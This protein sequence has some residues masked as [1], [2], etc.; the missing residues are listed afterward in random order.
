MANFAS[1]RGPV[2]L[3]RIYVQTAAGADDPASRRD[4]WLSGL[5]AGH[6]MATNGPILSF[7]LA[8]QPPGGELNCLQVSTRWT[9]AASCSR[10]WPSTTWKSCT[11]A[12]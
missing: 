2:G 6:T 9:S 7:T 1:L 12:R 10:W 11:T 3:N 4:R 5:K 8:G